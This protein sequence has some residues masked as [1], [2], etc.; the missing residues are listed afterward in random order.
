MKKS[1]LF[2]ALFILSTLSTPAWAGSGVKAL[3]NEQGCLSCHSVDQKMV[4]PSFKQVAERYRGKKG[5][6]SMLAKKI[7]DGGNGHWNDLTGGM[8]M[9]PHPNLTKKQARDIAAW[10]LSLK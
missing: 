6:L 8:M 4:G 3:I 9:P 10:V 2:L 5:S 1:R 7:I